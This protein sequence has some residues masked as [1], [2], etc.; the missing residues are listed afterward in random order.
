MNF[1]SSLLILFLFAVA[2]IGNA[3]ENPPSYYVVIGGFRI[4]KNAQ[5]FTEYAKSVKL[6]ASYSFNSSRK[7]FY[8]YVLVTQAKSESLALASTL[9]KKEKFKDVWVF[10]GSLLNDN[11][12]YTKSAEITIKEEVADITTVKEPVIIKE[13]PK[14]AGIVL[15]V[16]NP[17]PVIVEEKKPEGKPFVFKLVNTATDGTVNGMVHLQESEKSNQY[18]GYKANEK[19]YVVAPANRAKR[20]VVRC[21]VIGFKPYKEIID[22]LKPQGEGIT[23]GPDQEVIVPLPLE[24][25]KKGDYIEMDEVKFYTF[26]SILM[27]ASERELNELFA[28]MEENPKY[29]IK[30]HGHSNSAPA[31]E[32][33]TLGTSDNFFEVNE[34]NKRSN[35][36]LKE[37][38]TERAETIKRYLIS[39]GIDESRITTRGEGDK[40]LMFD[41][42]G[43]MASGNDRVEVEIV[44]A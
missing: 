44:K 28:M 15:K 27:P 1:R 31:K 8:V 29:K 38:S 12:V 43:T 22:Y 35:G 36:S 2:F 41:P 3:Q 14:D 25:V 40:Q 16:N 9:R 23:V 17:E 24:R 34:N 33:L 6:N 32:I 10:E 39:R 18:R 30:L 11:D 37:L 20:W 4:E 19:V 42:K 13:E 21:S 7:I 26:S 5:R